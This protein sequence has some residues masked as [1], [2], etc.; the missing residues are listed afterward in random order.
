[1]S[2]DYSPWHSGPELCSGRQGRAETLQLWA[3]LRQPESCEDDQ[4]G[5]HQPQVAKPG[6]DQG[7]ERVFF[8]TRSVSFL[9]FRVFLHKNRTSGAS[10]FWF[11][12]FL[13][14]VRRSP[15]TA[16]PTRR[17]KRSF[18]FLFCLLNIVGGNRISLQIFAPGAP[19]KAPEGAH[20]L[21]TVVM[22][23]CFVQ[24]SLFLLIRKQFF[25]AFL[26][27]IPTNRRCSAQ[28]SSCYVPRRSRPSKRV[29]SGAHTPDIYMVT[30]KTEAN[31][32]LS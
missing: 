18:S 14:T 26:S 31:F 10:A 5:A 19:L 8:I 17:S 24:V 7:C 6:V 1:M 28:F 12:R 13:A 27:R 11:G 29:P 20:S 21:A 23:M 16:S 25:N 3:R 4:S 30:Q 22:T 2:L 32:I 9:N 15:S